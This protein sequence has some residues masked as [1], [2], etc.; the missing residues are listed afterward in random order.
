MSLQRELDRVETEIDKIRLDPKYLQLKNKKRSDFDTNRYTKYTRQLARLEVQKRD[1]TKKM[2]DAGLKPKKRES[3]PGKYVE[4]KPA[5][6]NQ[7]NKVA[8]RNQDDGKIARNWVRERKEAKEVAPEFPGKRNAV[9]SAKPD[10]DPVTVNYRKTSKTPARLFVKRMLYH[11][12]VVRNASQMAKFKEEGRQRIER[13]MH[14]VNDT[15]RAKPQR[16]TT[17]AAQPVLSNKTAHEV[18]VRRK[19]VPRKSR[20]YTEPTPRK[21][22]ES[23][24]PTP[25]P[26]P[27]YNSSVED[28]SIEEVSVEEVSIEDVSIED[29]SIE[30]ALDSVEEESG[31]SGEYESDGSSADNIDSEEVIDDLSN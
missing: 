13:R 31:E 20:A 26:E 10:P 30:E 19:R 18:P 16:K 25:T 5:W 27:S 17:G 29:V 9:T 23:P 21:Q 1:V 7:A 14:P 11:K 2:R 4:S 22:R 15:V 24:V 28:V 6:R 12:Q 3:A 8:H